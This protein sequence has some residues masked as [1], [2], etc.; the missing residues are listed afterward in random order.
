MKARLLVLTVAALLLCPLGALAQPMAE[1]IADDA[2]VYVGWKGAG[3][4]AGEYGQ[5]RL[6]AVLDA[7]T[8]PRLLGESLPAALRQ[9]AGNDPAVGQTIEVIMG[10]GAVVWEQ[11]AAFV[12][13]GFE[14]Q[15]GQVIPRMALLCK[16]GNQAE[17]LRKQLEGLAA[18]VK[19]TLPVSVAQVNDV[20]VLQVGRPVGVKGVGVQRPTLAQ[21]AAFAKAMAATQKDALFTL[22]L[23]APA[24]VRVIN[25]A[26]E[27]ESP[28]DRQ[29]WQVLRDVGGLTGIEAM[30]LTASFEGRDWSTRAVI[31]APAPRK[32]MIWAL[33]EGKALSDDLLRAIPASA[34][35][36]G[37][38]GL[39]G[40]RALAD[41]RRMVAQVDPREAR[42][43]EAVLA[44]ISRALK[45]DLDKD[46]LQA[47][48]EQWAYYLSP[49]VGTGGL[50]SL[51]LVNRLRNPA[52]AEQMLV[53]LE[54][55][56]N[57]IIAME[58]HGRLQIAFQPTKVGEVTL[59]RMSLPGIAPTWA[60][61][62]GNL[63]IGAYPQMVLEA[64]EQAGRPDKSLLE[65]PAYAAVRKQLGQKNI[66]MLD[67]LD[68]PRSAPDTYPL[69]LAVTRL[70]LGMANLQ[71]V[72]TPEMV[73]P[74]L[75]KIL[76]HL[77]PAGSVAWTDERGWHMQG[78]SPF[79]GSEGLGSQFHALSGQGQQFVSLGALLPAMS[80]ARGQ[81]K[82]TQCMNNLKQLAIG[83]IM[84]STDNKD[85]MPP[86]LGAT[87]MYVR[88]PR[89]YVCPEHP[90]NMAADQ[91]QMPAWIN[92]NSSYVYLGSGAR[93]GRMR[94]TA[95]TVLL[96]EKLEAGH[97]G[98]V[99]LAF[100]D[101]HVEQVPIAQARQMI[102]A[103]K[104]RLAA[105][106]QQ[107]GQ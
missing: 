63:F 25:Q 90:A 13:S 10:A 87:W 11:P 96:H 15:N 100:F 83:C 26:M 55:V 16:A 89:V 95:Q 62:D 24:I 52:Q 32:G 6:K 75:G 70:Y 80:K 27:G 81:A 33:L 17:A 64:V 91:G 98:R 65:S 20:L 61:K 105:E 107:P 76:P 47:L 60:I 9:V 48:G 103:S 12:L 104:Q 5:S 50:M 106:A 79:P 7:S 21:H 42:D 66:T 67:M 3:A 86:D 78:I 46:I 37:A 43:F 45:A 14:E 57:Q 69:I 8:L 94:M 68:L 44:E 18:Q 49:D 2:M 93:L 30:A 59:H 71:G 97:D 88:H 23:D 19:G 22:Y 85:T 35:W 74:P 36:A 92:A 72:Q 56:V 1:L 38:F 31:L 28:S 53:K 34:T 82:V 54:A 58:T 77:I 102:E 101:G 39:D 4:V 73:V 84:Y 99:N 29:V 51:M 40:S 41:V